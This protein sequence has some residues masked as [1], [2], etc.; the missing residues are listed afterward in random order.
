[1]DQPVDVA[2]SLKVKKETMA[3]L[4]SDPLITATHIATLGKIPSMV[5]Y[6][7]SSILMSVSE[8]KK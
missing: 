8:M 6:E 5:T 3:S 2:E 7:V 1:M 4:S